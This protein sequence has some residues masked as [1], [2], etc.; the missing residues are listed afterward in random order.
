MVKRAQLG[1]V[2]SFLRNGV[3]VKGLVYKIRDNSAL[4][5]INESNATSLGLETLSTVVNHKNYI[6]VEGRMLRKISFQGQVHTKKGDN[7]FISPAH[8]ICTYRPSNHK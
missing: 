3:K 4:V 8:F 1:D 7:C 5:K 6:V 2:I